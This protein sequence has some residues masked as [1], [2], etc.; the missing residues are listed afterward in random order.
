[1]NEAASENGSTWEE[2][3][4]GLGNKPRSHRSSAAWLMGESADGKLSG[5]NEGLVCC[6]QLQTLSP[7]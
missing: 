1:M 6:T 5:V 2:E 3:G 4:K 7:S